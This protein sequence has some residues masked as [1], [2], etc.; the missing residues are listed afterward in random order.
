MQ[1]IEKDKAERREW[2]ETSAGR[3]EGEEKCWENVEKRTDS[4]EKKPT[5]S[6]IRL[7]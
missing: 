7:N 6:E 1:E 4:Q 5:P 3:K 2:G